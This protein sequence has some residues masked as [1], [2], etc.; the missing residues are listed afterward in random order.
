MQ[1]GGVSQRVERNIM[2]DIEDIES[3]E[4]ES[5]VVRTA[6]LT[7]LGSLGFWPLF[8]FAAVFMLPPVGKAMEAVM[9]RRILIDGMWIY[10]L[11]VG[12]A[13]FLS[14]RSVRRGSADIVCLLPWLIPALLGFYW[15]GYFLL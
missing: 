6:R 14:K 3:I 5:P 7:F 9:A 12:A 8:L 13:W 4:I 1:A 10:P 15:L 2:N 11:A